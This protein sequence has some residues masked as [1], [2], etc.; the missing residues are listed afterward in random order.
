MYRVFNMGL[1]LEMKCLQVK[2][3]RYKKLCL[4]NCEIMLYIVNFLNGGTIL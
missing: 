1:A 2:V 4:I 3:G